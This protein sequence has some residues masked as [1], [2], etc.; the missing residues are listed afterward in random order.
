MSPGANYS[1]PK[2]S[3]VRVLAEADTKPA[4]TAGACSAGPQTEAPRGCGLMWPRRKRS[5]ITD[6][7]AMTPKKNNR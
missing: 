6:K 1:N 3:L 4:L 5:T 2:G 7:A